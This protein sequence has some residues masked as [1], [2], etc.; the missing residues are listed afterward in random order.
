MFSKAEYW[1]RRRA[2]VR[3]Q[4]DAPTAVIIPF[5]EDGYPKQGQ[6][7]VRV[8]GKGLQRFNRKQY[9][10]RSV[11]RFATAKN[12]EYQ[13]AKSGFAHEV[14]KPGEGFDRRVA[15]TKG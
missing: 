2:G 11:L 6:H 10:K 13:H 1:E 7:L 14:N 15:R 3:G 8:P 5:S 4:T 12:Y 9:R